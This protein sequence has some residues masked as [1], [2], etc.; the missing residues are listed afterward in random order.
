MSF[1]IYD[2][3]VAKTEM[4]YVHAHHWFGKIL[5]E[6]EIL[7]NYPVVGVGLVKV[8]LNMTERVL[9]HHGEVLEC[10]SEIST[11]IYLIHYSFACDLTLALE[12]DL[13]SW[14]DGFETGIEISSMTESEMTSM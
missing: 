8:R 6:I 13:F 4:I 10:A 5:E 7:S 2:G 9:D 14:S 3:L 1:A 11:S 12:Y